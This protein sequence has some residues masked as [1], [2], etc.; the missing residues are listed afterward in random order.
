MDILLINIADVRKLTNL[1]KNVD[2][3]RYKQYIIS[4]QNIQLK[5]IIGSEC[6]TDLLN[7]KCSGTL[8]QYQT[9]LLDLVKPFLINSSFSKYVYSS[10]VLST[11]EGLVK[12]EGDNI[13]HLTNQEKK[14]EFSFYDGNANAY[15]EQIIEL[16][17][18][19]K[20]N[21]PCYHSNGC[22]SCCNTN[23]SRT[24]FDL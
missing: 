14:Q 20:E 3:A 23:N 7:A 2:S 17:E 8:D 24:I 18:S 13:T 1:T 22:C 21:Y 19:D 6:L 15:Q 9:A 11:A 12:M 16:L 5:N 4:A 10:P